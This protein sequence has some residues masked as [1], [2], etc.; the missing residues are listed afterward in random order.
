M[1]RIFP[2]ES[3]SNLTQVRVLFEEYGAEWPGPDLDGDGFAKELTDLSSTYGPPHGRL[4]VALCDDQPAGC[5]ALRKLSDGVGEV[6]RLYVKPEF[7]NAGIGRRLVEAV[8][9]EARGIGFSRVL[10]DTTRAMERARALY[11]SVGFVETQRYHDKERR[12]DAVFMAL[13]LSRE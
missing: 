11:S 8:L 4:L 10:L 5:I 1:I 3:P 12:E 7:R 2:A 9:E 6:K 13:E